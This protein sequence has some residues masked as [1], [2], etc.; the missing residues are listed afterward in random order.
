MAQVGQT[1]NTLSGLNKF[2]AGGV[3]GIGKNVS[4]C[5][6]LPCGKIKEHLSRQ[7]RFGPEHYLVGQV[8]FF[9]FCAVVIREPVLRYIQTFIDEGVPVWRGVRRKNTYLAIVNFADGAA[10]LP[11]HPD[12]IV[13]FFDKTT[14]IED[15][16]TIRMTKVF[17]NQTTI[18]AHDTIVVPTGVGYKALHGP[19]FAPL[20][21]KGDGLDRFTF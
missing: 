5:K 9:T 10:V 17:G 18:F 8:A 4:K 15:N 21:S 7:L 2:R 11:G 1:C 20:Y 19:D 12:G 13:T 3:D 14:F 6:L 16:G